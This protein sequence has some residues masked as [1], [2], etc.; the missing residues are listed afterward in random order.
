MYCKHVLLTCYISSTVANID[1]CYD[2]E[3]GSTRHSAAVSKSQLISETL[4]L[5]S[6][7]P[8]LIL[9]SGFFLYVPVS[10]TI[11]RRKDRYLTLA[12]VVWSLFLEC[13]VYPSPS[14]IVY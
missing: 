1:P 13:R 9:S 3:V 7:I 10:R 14:S 2:D 12:Y 11:F 5:E 8:A 6:F 4:H